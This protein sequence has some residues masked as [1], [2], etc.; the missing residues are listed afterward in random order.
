MLRWYDSYKVCQSTTYCSSRNTW[1]VRRRTDLIAPDELLTAAI[2]DME[3]TLGTVEDKVQNH[4]FE[5]AP[6]AHVGI[7]IYI[8]WGR[9]LRHKRPL[10]R[11]L[12]AQR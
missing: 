11:F 6:A 3:H 10:R 2:Y 12:G 8:R 7:P 5:A 9:L 4:G 1:H